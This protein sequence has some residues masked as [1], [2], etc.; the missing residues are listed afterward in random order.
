MTRVAL[1]SHSRQTAILRHRQLI[2]PFLAADRPDLRSVPGTKSK[3]N[4]GRFGA[5][6]C[7]HQI[8]SAEM[9]LVPIWCRGWIGK[10]TK[11]GLVSI[12][13]QTTGFALIII[14]DL[15]YFF[16]V[17]FASEANGSNYTLYCTA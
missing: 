4:C 1:G 10:N 17:V 8:K 5:W 13:C 6:Y 15:F 7:R 11:L 2:V 9:D 3:P 12:W 16:T 14:K